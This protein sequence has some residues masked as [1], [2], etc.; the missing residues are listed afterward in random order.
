MVAFALRWSA[1]GGVPHKIE[2][3]FG[4]STAEYFHRLAEHLDADPPAP[5]P[6]VVETM[7][8]LARKRLWLCK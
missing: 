3:R 8:F 4:M 2:H 1:H 7:N 5:R 6:E